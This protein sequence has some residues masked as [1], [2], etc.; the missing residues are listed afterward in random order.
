MRES[1]V[2]AEECQADIIA[3]GESE[4]LRNSHDREPGAIVERLVVE[5]ERRVILRR[6]DDVKAQAFKRCPL[7]ETFRGT[8]A[9]SI[10]DDD[11]PE[12]PRTRRAK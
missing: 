8:V 1:G 9:R 12:R 7:R 3:A 10:I 5:S 6:I 2:A 11:D 4:I